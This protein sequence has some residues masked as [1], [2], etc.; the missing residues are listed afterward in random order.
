MP[1]YIFRS[2]SDNSS[3]F[4]VSQYEDFYSFVGEIN[5][6]NGY[7]AILPITIEKFYRLQCFGI[8]L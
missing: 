1:V 8:I 5:A 7:K 2:L 4:W 6:D 3:V